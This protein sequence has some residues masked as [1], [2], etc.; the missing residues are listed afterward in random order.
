M[1]NLN[2]ILFFCSLIFISCKKSNSSKESVDLHLSQI[3]SLEYSVYNQ[4]LSFLGEH[5]LFNRNNYYLPKDFQKDLFEQEFENVDRVKLFERFSEEKIDTSNIPLKNINFLLFSDSITINGKLDSKKIE[6]NKIN[7]PL[8]T[9]LI[10][11]NDDILNYGVEPVLISLSRVI[12]NKQKTKAEYNFEI[13]HSLLNGAGYKVKCE[14]KNGAWIV[15]KKEMM[16]IS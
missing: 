15:V 8:G 10:S 9:I 16:W 14:F 13:I 11:E 6:L 1:R 3:D 5:I 2:Y 7:R 4:T 12:F